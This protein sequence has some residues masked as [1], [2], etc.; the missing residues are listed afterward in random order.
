VGSIAS[1]NVAVMLLPTGT[2]IADVAGTV[3]VTVGDTGGGTPFTKFPGVVIEV[4]CNVTWLRAK[5]R[6]V[7]LAPVLSITCFTLRIFPWNAAP[8]PIT[9]PVGPPTCQKTLLAR[10][11]PARVK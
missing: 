4:D 9:A 6:P 2:P 3:D 5:A 10:A 7:R 11:P 8:V 1:L